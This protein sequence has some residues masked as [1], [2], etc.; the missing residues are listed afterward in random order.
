M[1]LLER[2]VS[3]NGRAAK[4]IEGQ[5]P[6]GHHAGAN[7][8]TPKPDLLPL[9][10]EQEQL[11]MKQRCNILVAVTGTELDREIMTLACNV[12]Q[13]KHGDVYAIYGIEVPRTLA[14]DAEMPDE[15]QLAGDALERAAAVAQQLGVHI[16]PEIVQSR[17]FGQ[18]L[19]DEAEAHHC[20]L[21]VLGM[22]YK[23]SF[24]GNFTYGNTVEFALKNAPCRVWLVRGQA[25]EKADAKAE[26]SERGVH[27]EQRVGV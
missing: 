27:P 25:P 22:P 11:H 13:Q 19:V 2:L 9:S 8:N 20:A 23:L 18:S 15:T 4:V 26:A 5:H 3:P 7:E 17:H 1:G 10:G 14:V 24:G 6:G 16:E 21:L 12:A